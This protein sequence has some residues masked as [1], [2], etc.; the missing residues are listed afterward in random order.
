MKLT[1]DPS[2]VNLAKEG[3]TEAVLILMRD[4][5]KELLNNNLR[6][7]ARAQIDLLA[8]YD[9][10]CEHLLCHHAKLA[11]TRGNYEDD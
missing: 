11:Q 8:L 10:I 7:T 9:D 6:L 4:A 1:N 2:I 3:E 5:L